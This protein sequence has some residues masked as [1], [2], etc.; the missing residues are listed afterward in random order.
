MLF[1]IQLKP[2]KII[3]IIMMPKNTN[4]IINDQNK[5]GLSTIQSIISLML[6]NHQFMG[7]VVRIYSFRLFNFMRRTL[8]MQPSNEGDITPIRSNPFR[9]SSNFLLDL[10]WQAHTR[11][12]FIILDIFCFCFPLSLTGYGC[13]L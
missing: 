7:R 12:Q 2:L 3:K 11:K 6:I 9:T 8:L 4:K 1:S 5:K 10:K 13:K